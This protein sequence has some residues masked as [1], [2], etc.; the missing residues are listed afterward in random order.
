MA[1]AASRAED[2][3]GEC[4]PHVAHTAQREAVPASGLDGQHARLAPLNAERRS[5]LVALLVLKRATQ[6]QG[7][8]RAARVL[9]VH[10]I[11]AMSEMYGGQ[12]SDEIQFSELRFSARRDLHNMCASRAE[13]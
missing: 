12:G 4:E 10:L 9:P 7:L 8:A 2:A 5:R 11:P 3:A 6:V 1:R 13:S